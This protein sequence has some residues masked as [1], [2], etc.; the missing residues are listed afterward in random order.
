MW[1]AHIL[2]RLDLK[3]KS[4][5]QTGA[6]V[7]IFSSLMVNSI[8]SAICIILQLNNSNHFQVSDDEDIL[9]DEDIRKVTSLREKYPKLVITFSTNVV[10]LFEKYL[11]YY[12][13]K[14]V[15]EFFSGWVYLLRYQNLD[16]LDLNSDNIVK[17]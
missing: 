3:L 15:S 2:I 5:K 8:Y 9:R 10:T 4:K 12:D 17:R 16:G 7:H 1:S 11:D 13:G 6:N 14:N